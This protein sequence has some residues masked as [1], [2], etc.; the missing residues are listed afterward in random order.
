[1]RVTGKRL[2]DSHAHA[3]RGDA[4]QLASSDCHPSSPSDP[5][6]YNFHRAL[7]SCLSFAVLSAATICDGAVLLYES[8]ELGQVGVPPVNFI[9]GETP[10]CNVDTNLYQGVKFYLSEATYVE[11]V[12]A[13]LVGFGAWPYDGNQLGQLFAAVV[14]LDGADDFPDSRDLS[15]PDVVGVSLIQLPAT[16]NDVYGEIGISLKR[17][18]YALVL[19]AGLFG[20]DAETGIGAMVQNNTDIGAPIYFGINLDSW[21]IHGSY[22]ANQRFFLLGHIVPEPSVLTL[23]LFVGLANAL[24]PGRV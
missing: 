10:G 6:N 8:S 9:N 14:R 13:H 18:W 11:Q 22:A 2:G 23:L 15:T 19:G 17:G 7:I 12:G 5:M 3:A 1:M 16:S 20:S 4:A 21:Y 24:F